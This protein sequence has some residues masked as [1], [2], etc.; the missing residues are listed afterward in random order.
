M[1]KTKESLTEQSFEQK[2]FFYTSL[3]LFTIYII[4]LIK[5]AWLCDDAYIT[6]RTIDNFINGYGLR[7]NVAERVQSYTHPLWLFVLS[8]IYF[9][10]HEIFFSSLILSIIIS[11]ITILILLFVLSIRIENKLLILFALIFSKAYTDYSTSGLENPLT[12]LLL[13][14][15]L[16]V[17]FKKNI[18]KKNIF[19]LS[20]LSG[21][22]LLNRMDCILLILP[23]LAF[24]L[25]KYRKQANY[26]IVFLGFLPFLLWE[27]FSLWYYGFLFPNT[28]YAKLNTDIDRLE[29][30]IQ[31]FKYFSSSFKLDPLTLTV[32]FLSI[33]LS[34]FKSN[35]KYLSFSIGI[36]FY[37]IYIISV[38]GDF[39]AGRFFSSPFL[40]S[41]IILGGLTIKNTRGFLFLL[42]LIIIIG[43]V[44][45][46][47]L[48]I[49]NYGVIDKNGI[50]DERL[51][52]YKSSNLIYGLKGINVPN[53]PNW[54]EDGKRAKEENLE[55]I[56]LYSIGFFGFY[57]GPECFILDKLALTDPLLA[58]LP[59][60]KNWRI[61][62]FFR[63]IPD[64]YELSLKTGKNHIENSD[65]AK[66]YSK[67][68]LIT[69][70]NLWDMKRIKE[71]WKI[72]TGQ[73]LYLI[74]N[75]LKSH[76]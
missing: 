36:I 32:I 71:I 26:L 25:F 45:I 14:L 19:L 61:G 52:Y 50:S 58:R 49:K 4:L 62:H 16:L 76:L 7:W 17:Y 65:L 63:K 70:G 72:N 51:F 21:L 40:I 38:G 39:M 22:I 6:F 53:F 9:F 13:V 1:D 18:T 41:L 46:E 35:R 75:Y 33:I 28:A 11:I 2:I 31:G 47:N 55:F 29:L 54:V 43:A 12:N 37:L 3:L 68:L 27:L 30:I 73:Y 74:Q 59:A 34:I 60:T 23:S 67:I 69:R 5:T 15:Y 10:T 20:L 57:A 42:S 8:F 64:G 56:S 66:Y 48:F 24:Y 44:N